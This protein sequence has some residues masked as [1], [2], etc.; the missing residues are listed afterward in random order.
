MNEHYWAMACIRL[1][2]ATQLNDRYTQKGGR[3]V[4]EIP[5]GRGCI[6]FQRAYFQKG[7]DANSSDE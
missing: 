1:Q 5:P 3:W 4:S 7:H 2:N 6:E